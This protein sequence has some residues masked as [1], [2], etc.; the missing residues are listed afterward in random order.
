VVL[1]LTKL[2]LTTALYVF[3]QVG[4]SSPAESGIIRDLGLSLAQVTMI[5]ARSVK[6]KICYFQLITKTILQMALFLNLIL[7][8]EYLANILSCQDF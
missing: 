2:N 8:L 1:N 7:V 3:M 4:Y 6:E 5:I